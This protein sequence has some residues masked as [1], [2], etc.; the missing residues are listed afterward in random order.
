[1]KALM[2]AIAFSLAPLAAAAQ[3]APQAPQD[4]VSLPYH[5]RITFPARSI[6]E[7]R[8]AT[9]SAE[10]RTRLDDLAQQAKSS[11]LEVMIAVEYGERS[12]ERA[13]A[14]REY[15][16]AAN[17]PASRVYTEAQPRSGRSRLVIEVIGAR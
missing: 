10:G 8:S 6:F 2:L 7:T 9:L 4:G 12:I 13:A 5:R 17:I 15:L 11:D 3:P 16:L 14:V 1:M